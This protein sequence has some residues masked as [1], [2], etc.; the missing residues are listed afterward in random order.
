MLWFHA[1]ARGADQDDR[2]RLGYTVGWELVGLI[3]AV[4]TL[5]LLV[6]AAALWVMV[7]IFE[8]KPLFNVKPAL[9]D[10]RAEEVWFPTSHGLT[11]RGSL[12]RHDDRRAR[13]LIIFC[14]EMS[15]SHWS[16]PVYCEGLCRAGFDVFAFDFR[17]QGE[18][19]HL[20]GYDPLHWVTEYEVTDVLAAIAFAR[21]RGGLSHLPIGLFGISRGGGAAL[22]AAARSRDVRCIACEGAFATETMH[23]Y[24]TERWAAL[25]IPPWL[26]RL[27]PRWHLRQ[28]LTLGRWMSQLRRN[29][30]YAAFDRW[31]PNLCNRPLLLITGGRDTY[32]HPEIAERMSRAIGSSQ[33]Q[34]WHVPEARH[35]AARRV[36]PEDYDRRLVEFFSCL[37]PESA[38]AEVE[39]RALDNE[40]D[41]AI[42]RAELAD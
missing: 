22:I 33:A 29:C 30:R 26:M 40:S 4:L 21:Q 7:P 36:A 37:S 27:I 18:S 6:R 2:R 20:P 9:P 32:V 35:N 19:D 24:Y 34:V 1:A 17:N 42:Q 5:D 38:A 12:Y 11:L 13:G 31:L 3:A 15:G 28:T 10:P 41:P 25:Y 8:R 39:R 23:E 16:A 14:P